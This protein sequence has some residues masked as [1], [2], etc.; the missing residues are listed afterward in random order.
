[1][2][3]A[4]LI[5]SKLYWRYRSGKSIEIGI[6]FKRLAA[7]L[8]F[9]TCYI[10]PMGNH[11]VYGESDD[12]LFI[13][14]KG[15]VGIGNH[16]PQAKLDVTGNIIG[17]GM[18]PPGGIVMFHGDIDKSFDAEGTGRKN[19]PYEG[20]QLCN[21]ENGAPDLRGRFVLGAGQGP[22]LTNRPM[23]Q[24]GGEETHILANQEIPIHDHQTTISVYKPNFKS[25]KIYHA[26]NSSRTYC[27]SAS[28]TKPGVKT[29]TA[30]E[31]KAHNNMPPFYTLA[32]IMRL[33]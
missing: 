26:W 16:E 8:I 32:F 33:P 17:V 4:E 23:G 19:T 15:N 18:V 21:G 30:G 25:E 13:D 28:E 24:S 6:L 22:N 7:F 12:A 1:M 5:Q 11:P 31:G 14:E 2:K 3:S 9:L 29:T 20:W 27:Y 10:V